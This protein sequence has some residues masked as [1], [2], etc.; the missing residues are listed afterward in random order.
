MPRNTAYPI[1]K[2]IALVETAKWSIAP[3][4][5]S[6]YASTISSFLPILDEDI[7]FGG[8]VDLNYIREY[9]EER[10]STG[11]IVE[12]KQEFS[13]LV[14]YLL[15]SSI[16]RF[17]YC[18]RL[19][20][21]ISADF[22]NG[23]ERYPVNKA[24]TINLN[25]C[26]GL[27]TINKK[28]LFYFIFRGARMKQVRTGI[29]PGDYLGL[30]DPSDDS[31]KVFMTYRHAR[32][33]VC[34]TESFQKILV[35]IC[36]FEI[37]EEFCPVHNLVHEAC[38]FDISR[39]GIFADDTLVTINRKVEIIKDAFPSSTLHSFR[40]TYVVYLMD[41]MARCHYSTRVKNFLMVA[42]GEHLSW[43]PKFSDIYSNH[44]S[45]AISKNFNR[46]CNEEVLP[47]NPLMEVYLCRLCEVLKLIYNQKK[48]IFHFQEL[49]NNPPLE[50]VE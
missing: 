40:R 18:Q 47:A 14:R 22:N 16:M 41:Y 17:Q 15:R 2:Q 32:E 20:G 3:D 37:Y 25:R 5:A 10:I 36:D 46:Y 38:C 24:C 49:I 44:L 28:Y 26:Y 27:S 42:I 31:L 34:L 50:G 23:A 7:G 45:G 1:Y 35:C 6:R 8:E 12:G 19:E 48:V 13:V 39:V 21:L 9:V 30:R 4:T 43:T 29:C 33:K 11:S